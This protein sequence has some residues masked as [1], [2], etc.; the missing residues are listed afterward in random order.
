MNRFFIYVFTLLIISGCVEIS[1]KEKSND[2]AMSKR[3]KEI[4][5]SVNECSLIIFASKGFNPGFNL[6]TYSSNIT[7]KSAK[8]LD[9][10]LTAHREITDITMG[11]SKRTDTSDIKAAKE[12]FKK[13]EPI[14]YTIYKYHSPR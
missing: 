1:V 8:E 13:H 7:V 14:K 3:F 12:V 6:Q 2:D 4:S 11:I 9:D 5:D 10:Y